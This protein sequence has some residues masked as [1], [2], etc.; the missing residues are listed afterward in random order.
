MSY[1]SPPGAFLCFVYS[2]RGYSTFIFFFLPLQA[3]PLVLLLED[4]AL[5][6]FPLV[7][8]FLSRSLGSHS[9][10]LLCHTHLADLPQ[11]CKQP[12]QMSTAVGLPKK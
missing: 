10:K 5:E 6:V 7:I 1:S 11:G 2:H 3:T 8:P 4:R 12:S 9:G